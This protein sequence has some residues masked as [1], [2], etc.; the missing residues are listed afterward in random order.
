M[1]AGS[2]GSNALVISRTRGYLI[3]AAVTVVAVTASLPLQRTFDRFPYLPL[4]VAAVIVSA[5]AGGLGPGLLAAGGGAA[6]AEYLVMGGLHAVGTYPELLAQLTLFV[7]VAAIAT[8]IRAS[9]TRAAESR[10]NRLL[11]ELEERVKELSLLHRVTGLLQEDE[12]L[13]TLLRQLVGLL[14]AGWQF[15]ELLE[16]RITVADLV[17]STRQFEI[18]PWIQRAEFPIHDAPPGLLEVVYREAVS[19]GADGPFL[20]EE[21]SLLDSLATLLA[22]YFERVHRIEE[23]L[24]LARAQASQ[25]EAEAANRM[26]DAFLATVSHELRRPLTAMLGWTRMLREG[27]TDDSGRALEVIERNARIQLRLIEELL[28]LSRTATGQLG[29]TFSPVRLNVI[30]RNVAD[31]ARPAAVDRQVDIVTKLDGEDTTVLG[32][33]IRLQQIVGN[34]V[35]NAIKF[36]PNGG[37]VT[38]ALER[39]A[40][41][42]RVVVA[43]TG[44]GID[45]AVLPHIFERFWQADPS[46]PPSREGLG[47]G[48][49]I[50]RRL[51]ELHG[52][53]IEAHSAGSGSGTRM[54]VSLPLAVHGVSRDAPS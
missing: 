44:I 31:A 36:T 9:R 12:D 5:W 2:G 42:A 54:T 39:S 18:T 50:V 40:E 20:Q 13:E 26:K 45:P 7:A 32:D 49:S 4:L 28:D 37:R 16:A 52:G 6:V 3:A 22:S 29:V 19:A 11:W 34:L 21:R 14:P 15:P 1:N 25:I 46:A 41:E 35:A 51:V 8:S 27:H 38:L 30:L 10:R 48:L 23:R 24:E 33:G 17:V 43:D 53:T 47:L